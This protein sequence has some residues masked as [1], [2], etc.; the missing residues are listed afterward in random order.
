[1]RRGTSRF[2]I[3][4]CDAA[5]SEIRNRM[6]FRYGKAVLT[7]APLLHVRV[8]IADKE[9]ETA[10]GYSADCLP[11]LWFDK[12][13]SKTFR[14]NVEDQLTAFRR[15]RQVYL[16]A[17]ERIRPAYEIWKDAYP[18]VHEECAR[19][20]LNALTASFGSSF[21]ERAMIDALCRLKSTTFFDALQCDLLGLA[22]AKLVPAHA[23][24][25][26][27]IR[28]TVGLS[29][30]LT[31]GEI[32]PAERIADG[33]PQ[34]LEE[35]I[36][37]YGLSYFKVKVAG[38]PERD[39]ERL[40]RLAALIHQRCLGGYKITLDG[41]EQFRD[42]AT[43]ER[44]L[45]ALRSRP[46]GKEFLDAILYVEQPLPREMALDPSAASTIAS[47]S[48]WKPVIIDE[49]DDRLDSFARA[50]GLGYLGVSHKNCKG[51]FKSLSHRAW[52]LEQNKARRKEKAPLF[53]Q[54]GE[55][56]ATVPVVPLQQDLASLAGLG[57]DHAEKNGHHYFR[58]LDHLPPAEAAAALAA[59]PDLYDKRGDFIHLKIQDGVVSLR[60]VLAGGYGYSSAISFDDRVPLADWTFDRLDAAPARG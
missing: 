20:G 51:I 41:N 26:I 30:P 43:L 6:P 45:E 21:L 56:L 48:S 31:R 52:I 58:G 36:E 34:A 33:L 42:I 7:A 19:A 50:T 3:V 13:P 47:I 39:L 60:S 46:Y 27:H 22:T 54:T 11:P 16:V 2:R 53:F 15:A 29:D 10:V 18:K 1:M 23:A 5:M 40:S 4:G 32:P 17:G 24:E 37:T 12:D 55:D 28:H 49:S 38:D 14:Q 8:S 9:G 25:S 35:D 57:I 59:H 44:L